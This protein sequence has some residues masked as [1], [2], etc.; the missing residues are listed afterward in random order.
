MSRC[1]T[2]KKLTVAANNA[3]HD[4]TSQVL[5][6]L[7]LQL[8]MAKCI[9]LWHHIESGVLK[10]LPLTLATWLEGA[11]DENRKKKNCHPLH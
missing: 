11:C 10:K 8:N 9:E 3:G 1:I 4:R 5:T 2:I 6:T 7:K